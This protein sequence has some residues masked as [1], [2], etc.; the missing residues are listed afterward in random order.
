MDT[1]LSDMNAELRAMT[2]HAHNHRP[3]VRV[4]H[5]SPARSRSPETSGQSPLFKTKSGDDQKNPADQ[6][7]RNSSHR[8]NPDQ[9]SRSSSPMHQSISQSA[10]PIRRSPSP[11]RQS[12][13]PILQRPG[14]ATRRFAMGRTNSVSFLDQEEGEDSDNQEDENNEDDEIEIQ[15]LCMFNFHFSKKIN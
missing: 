13:S 4:L 12:P 2:E 14:S 11:S 5:S 10:S 9:F 7:T 3:N 1:G 15:F 6:Q 8:T